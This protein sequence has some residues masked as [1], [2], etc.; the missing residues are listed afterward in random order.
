MRFLENKT[1]HCFWRVA[2]IRFTFFES[3]TVAFPGSRKP[4]REGVVSRKETRLLLSCLTGSTLRHTCGAPR[5][6]RG[7][8]ARPRRR[9]HRAR[10]DLARLPR[11][12]ERSPAGDAPSIGEPRGHRRRLPPPA[13]CRRAPWAPPRRRPPPRRTTRHP[14]PA[15]PR[16]RSRRGCA[17]TASTPGSRPRRNRS[18]RNRS[19]SWRPRC[20]GVIRLCCQTRTA[21]LL[22]ASA[23]F[24]C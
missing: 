18:P 2:R 16:T 8:L 7:A 15:A 6:W 11:V 22:D 23:C 12:P 4:F 9:G 17:R 1:C 3:W 5:V 19:S 10:S 13:R 20:A 24:G 21:P 14:G